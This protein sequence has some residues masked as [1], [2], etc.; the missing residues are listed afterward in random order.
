MNAPQD[1]QSVAGES[2]ETRR[3]TLLAG[4]A[5]ILPDTAVLWKAEDTVPYECDGLAAYRQ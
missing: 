5:R 1:A 2:A 3:A 4:L